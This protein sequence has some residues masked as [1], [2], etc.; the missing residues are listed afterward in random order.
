MK[1]PVR[2][3]L[4]RKHAT[5]HDRR[6]I[7][8]LARL[9][10]DT[11]GNTLILVAIAIV[12]LM[13]MIGSGVDI[14]RAYMADVRLQQACDAGVLA[15]RR[16][17]SGATLSDQARTEAENYFKFN[18][19]QGTLQTA[20]F[21]PSIT[22]PATGTIALAANTT[23]PTSIM[24]MFGYT[25]LPISA[26]CKATQ[27]FVN[28][29]V[30]LVF[31]TSGSM[32]CAP[33]V[34]GDCGGIEQIGSKID[35]LR[36]A[37]DKLYDTLQ[38]AQDQ[39]HN[40]NLRLRYGFV[41]YSSG[42]N[43]GKLVYAKNAN[44]IVNTKWTYQSRQKVNVKADMGKADCDAL[45]GSWKGFSIFNFVI[46]GACQLPDSKYYSW[47]YGPV[48]HS[49]ADYVSKASST[50]PTNAAATS[51]WAGCIEERKTDPVLVDGGSGSIAP[52]TAFDL[53]VN[54]LP[55]NDDSRWRPWW[56]EVEY[57]P[58]GTKASGTCPTEARRLREYFNDKASYTSYITG[59]KA[60]GGTYHD[61]GMIWGARFISQD[62]IFKSATP[63]TNNVSD[64]DNPKKIRGFAV[65]KYL[66]FMTDGELAP[67]DSVYSTYG[68]ERLDKRVTGTAATGT[69]YNRHLQRFRMACNAAKSQGIE[70]WVIAFATT[71]TTDMQNC[72]SRPSNAAGITTT[73]ALIAK[74]AEIGSKI[75]SLRLS[76]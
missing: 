49:V 59:L 57:F 35:G 62:G 69:Q 47:S 20:P 42:V 7:G 56:P 2:Q 44:Y 45:G 18:F 8:L 70:V 74:F 38:T 21:T 32:N 60:T 58:D 71:L 37:S 9:R 39:L 25:Q 31:D 76:Q 54:L 66:I 67:T 22:V 41:T 46:P 55:T 26:A 50:T 4:S 65:K 13:A 3:F 73:P 1:V 75:G 28:T 14:T 29:D 30:M 23:V 52:G 53:D 43:V 40:N 33:G 68:I 10:G 15:G 64:P 72:A 11:R 16:F 12:P 61:L 27:D 51:T 48:D 36:D 19:P 34:G 5:R 24:R 63:E 17:L 6:D